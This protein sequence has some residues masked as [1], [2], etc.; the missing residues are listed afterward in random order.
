[1]GGALDGVAG[2]LLNLLDGVGIAGE[3]G[4]HL[5]LHPAHHQDGVLGGEKGKGVQ[6][7]GQQGPACGLA[8]HLGQVHPLGVQAGALAGGQHQG[9]EGNFHIEHSLKVRDLSFDGK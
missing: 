9:L 1:M 8:Q 6:H 2:A 4:G 5:V 3:D 7:I